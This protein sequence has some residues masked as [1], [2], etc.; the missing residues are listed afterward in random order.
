M[1]IKQ[2]T[3]KNIKYFFQGY[4]YLGLEKL[5]WLSL[6]LKHRKEQFEFRK[7]RVTKIHP[8]CIKNKSCIHCGCATPALFLADKAC[9]LGC[10]PEIMTKKQWFNS[11]ERIEYLN[12]K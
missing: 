12:N 5:K 6:I 2:I 9:E 1:N 11:K 3:L 8:D 7:Q 4:F 10:Y